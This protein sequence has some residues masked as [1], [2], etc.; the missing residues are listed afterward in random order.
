MQTV[1]GTVVGWTALS[2]IF[3]PLLAWVFF[4]PERRADAIQAAHDHWIATHPM[5][6]LECMPAWLRWEDTEAG[7]LVAHCQLAGVD[8]VR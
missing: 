4:Y 6:P 3:G 1:I 5:S 7:D 8:A 2:C